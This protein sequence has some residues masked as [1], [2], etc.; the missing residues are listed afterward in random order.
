MRERWSVNFKRL[1]FV[2]L[3][4]FQDFFP[5]E[6]SLSPPSLPSTPPPP[7]PCTPPPYAPASSPPPPLPSV[8]PPD[9]VPLTP[10]PDFTDYKESNEFYCREE[11][12]GVLLDLNFLAEG[13]GE[14]DIACGNADYN[15][16][17]MC[18]EELEPVFTVVKGIDLTTI[19]HC[20]T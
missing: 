7:V 5:R 8:P 4:T 1:L 2:L 9:V 3:F 17:M 15:E 19:D 16:K 11:G 12:D 18:V 20:L 14:E 13:G 6:S 10:P